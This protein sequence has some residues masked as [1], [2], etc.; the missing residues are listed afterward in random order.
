M[1]DDVTRTLD[2]TPLTGSGQTHA[3]PRPGPS[4]HVHVTLTRV[5]VTAALSGD[6]VA[7]VDGRVL[8]A[9]P[10]VAD[11]EVGQPRRES[12]KGDV[13]GRATT[14]LG[15]D[16]VGDTLEDRQTGNDVHGSPHAADI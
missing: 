2:V 4:G 15:P 16:D 8:P 12:N 14:R 9:R 5:S 6:L 3:R 7:P 1:S 10:P 11:G 13:K